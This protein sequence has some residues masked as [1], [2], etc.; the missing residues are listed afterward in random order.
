MRHLA[1]RREHLDVGPVHFLSQ[2]AVVKPIH[3]RAW[4]PQ[5]RHMFAVRSQCPRWR[6]RTPGL[7]IA[8][9]SCLT[10]RIRVRCVTPTMSM[11]FPKPVRIF[12]DHALRQGKFRHNAGH[13]PSA[14]GRSAHARLNPN[15]KSCNSVHVRKSRDRGYDTVGAGFTRSAVSLPPARDRDA[16]PPGG[17]RTP[18]E[19]IDVVPRSHPPVHE[20][21][22]SARTPRPVPGAHDGA[23][24]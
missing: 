1:R 21:Q 15:N 2:R 9:I 8:N 4:W 24:H 13:R 18:R 12:R 3:L 20:R 16:S 19:I 10:L 23:P 11:I 5:G 14:Y 6:C 7:N 17:A 22:R